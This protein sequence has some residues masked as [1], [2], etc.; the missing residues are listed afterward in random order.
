MK[1]N[2][3]IILN[4]NFVFTSILEVVL[5]CFSNYKFHKDTFYTLIY[6]DIRQSSRCSNFMKIKLWLKRRHA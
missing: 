2:V 4:P 1:F 3:I 6:K 5:P